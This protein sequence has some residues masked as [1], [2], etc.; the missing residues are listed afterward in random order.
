MREYNFSPDR[1]PRRSGCLCP[2]ACGGC[3]RDSIDPDALL[4]AVFI[5][6]IPVQLLSTRQGGQVFANTVPANPG[7]SSPAHLLEQLGIAND[8]HLTGL[9]IMATIPFL[10]PAKQSS[11][12][13]QWVRFWN[14]FRNRFSNRFRGFSAGRNRF[15]C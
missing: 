6:P 3:P 10:Q 12:L 11:G 5:F 4:V 15:R 7:P 2:L 14:K 1:P 8:L 9:D 13:S